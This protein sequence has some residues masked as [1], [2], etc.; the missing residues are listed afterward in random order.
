MLPTN[1]CSE[2]EQNGGASIWREMGR[3]IQTH[4]ELQQHNS[5]NRAKS[6]EKGFK[7]EL[8]ITF[9][10]LDFVVVL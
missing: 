3:K 9:L 1:T 5:R 2:I 4:L 8:T 10:F 6:I 7:G